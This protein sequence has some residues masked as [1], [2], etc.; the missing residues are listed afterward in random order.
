MLLLEYIQ[1]MCLSSC[2]SIKTVDFYTNYSP[3][4][5]KRQI[6][7][8]STRQTS[9]R[10]FSKKK[11]KKRKKLARS[12]NFLFRYIDDVL[13]LNNSKF[14]NYDDCFYPIKFAIMNTTD[15]TLTSAYIFKRFFQLLY[16]FKV[17]KTRNLIQARSNL[18]SNWVCTCAS[19]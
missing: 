7:R 11:R 6:K 15:T 13:S 5:T 18:S 14:S 19:T 2:N 9:Y 4:T 3:L 1:S 10:G 16:S 8:I 17:H 12:F